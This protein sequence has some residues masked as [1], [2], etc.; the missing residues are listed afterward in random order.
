MGIKGYH[1]NKWHNVDS[2]HGYHRNK[3]HNVDKELSS[4]Q[5]GIMG[6]NGT[7]WIKSC[8]GYKGVS[9]E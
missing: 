8:H 4:A 7:K 2:H 5:N 6:I 3:W 1:G 9:W